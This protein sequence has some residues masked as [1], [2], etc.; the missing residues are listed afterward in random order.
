MNQQK[1]IMKEFRTTTP[2]MRNPEA[3]HKF[4]TQKLF[5]FEKRKNKKVA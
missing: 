4:P 3:N 1:R 2:W 5:V